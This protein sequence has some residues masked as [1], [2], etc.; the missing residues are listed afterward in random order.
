MS[1]LGTLMI[2]R[3]DALF[4]AAVDQIVAAEQSNGNDSDRAEL[5]AAL[6]RWLGQTVDFL[7]EDARHFTLGPDS[8][9]PRIWDEVKFPRE[10]RTGGGWLA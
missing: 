6:W 8:G 2:E 5:E 1:P 9:F 3:T 7:L 4:H 10:G